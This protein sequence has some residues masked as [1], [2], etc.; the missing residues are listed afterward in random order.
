M[1]NKSG[2]K[3]RVQHFALDAEVKKA[4]EGTFP[5]RGELVKL[6]YNN[7]TEILGYVED[8]SKVTLSS[9][10]STGARCC[11]GKNLNKKQF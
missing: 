6:K 5:V 4:T 10:S 7:D 8:L 2:D 9:S 11:Q 3:K 1:I